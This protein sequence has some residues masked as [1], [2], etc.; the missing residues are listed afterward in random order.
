MGQRDEGVACVEVA[1]HRAEIGLHRPE[2]GDHAGRNAVFLL[3]ASEDVGVLL[4]LLAADVEA[5][6]ADGALGEFEEGLLEDALRAVARQDLLVDL[7][8]GECGVRGLGRCARGNSFGLHA[9]EKGTEIAATL[10]GCGKRRCGEEGGQGKSKA[11]GG[12]HGII[13]AGSSCR[14]ALRPR[15]QPRPV[16][17]P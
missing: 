15:K 11:G 1:L 13:L 8:A 2:G 4:H 10:L 16:A 9:I 5:C 17:A 12:F 7:R 3:G 6:L 14:L